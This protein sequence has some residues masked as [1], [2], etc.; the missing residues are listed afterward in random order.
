MTKMRRMSRARN[1]TDLRI[2]VQPRPGKTDP[3]YAPSTSPNWSDAVICPAFDAAEDSHRPV[4]EFAV[5][6]PRPDH[7]GVL[8]V[9]ARFNV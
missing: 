4:W 7:V 6:G 9:H 8:D 2:E 3:V 5:R 1:P